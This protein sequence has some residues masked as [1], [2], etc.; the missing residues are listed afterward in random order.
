MEF[1]RGI[2]LQGRE[3]QLMIEATEDRIFGLQQLGIGSL[4]ADACLPSEA[5]CSDGSSSLPGFKA[6]L[7][8]AIQ[9]SVARVEN[10]V[11]LA[12]YPRR[13]TNFAQTPKEV[14]ED[15]VRYGH[16]GLDSFLT[17]ASKEYPTW[18]DLND[19]QRLQYG[20][21]DSL[22]EAGTLPWDLLTSDQRREF[23]NKVIFVPNKIEN[24]ERIDGK[25]RSYIKLYERYA[26]KIHKLALEIQ[27]PQGL[28]IPYLNRTYAP[29]EYFLYQK[30]GAVI[31]FPA[32]AK[33]S[34]TGASNMIASS[35]YGLVVPNMPQ[36]I[37]VDYEFGLKEIPQDLQDAVAL[38]S[39]IKTFELLN[40]AFTKGMMSYSVQG[41]SAAFGKGLYADV[42]Q[43]YKDEADELLHPYYAM[44]MTGY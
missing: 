9:R 29:N 43:R 33:I 20:N 41:F 39:A 14:Y 10:K 13:K 23:S 30:E 17:P 4:T 19:E 11:K 25:G 24:E 32:Q 27:D 35:G 18:D 16:G 26:T 44:I 42:M 1:S 31:L 8:R 22:Y 40:I 6:I 2:G 38:Y 36:I 21:D 28:G 3:L 34:A 7:I 5:R 37:A 15:R 12:L